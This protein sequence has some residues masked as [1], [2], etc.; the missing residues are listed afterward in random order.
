MSSVAIITG[1]AGGDECTPMIGSDPQTTPV[2]AVGPPV[3][4]RSSKHVKGCQFRSR[5]DGLDH[6]P[7]AG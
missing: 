6:A 5:F 4:M 1:V 2:C 3:P 7:A